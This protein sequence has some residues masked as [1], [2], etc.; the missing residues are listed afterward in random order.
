MIDRQGPPT[1]LLDKA[2]A[3]WVEPTDLAG[4][5]YAGGTLSLRRQRTGWTIRIHVGQPPH[6]AY[7]GLDEEV[8][9][10]TI[11]RRQHDVVR[12]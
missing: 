5:K 1:Q 6:V 11:V 4:D 2:H 9:V 10:L 7:A 3:R 8:Q 12:L